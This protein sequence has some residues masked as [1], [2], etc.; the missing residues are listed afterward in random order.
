[1]GHKLLYTNLLP[2]LTIYPNLTPILHS[3]LGNIFRFVHSFL[4][5]I[6]LMRTFF[7]FFIYFSLSINSLHETHSVAKLFCASRSFAHT[8][9]RKMKEE[10]N[11]KGAPT[12]LALP[13]EVLNG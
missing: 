7:F 10:L 4:N 9:K 12:Y 13:N 11:M 1:M 6:L 5:V 2:L 3:Y 8:D